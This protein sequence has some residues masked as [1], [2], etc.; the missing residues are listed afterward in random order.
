MSLKRNYKLNMP[1]LLWGGLSENWLLKELGDVHWEQITNE[2]GTASDALVDSRGE[3][4]YASFVRLFWS[5][6]N[7]NQFSEND[8]L[9]LNSDLSRYGS[10]MFFSQTVCSGE[11]GKFNAHLMSVFSTRES[12]DN[13]QLKRGDLNTNINAKGIKQHRKLPAFAK[14]YLNNKAILFEEK[15]ELKTT[16]VLYRQ[17]YPIDAYDDINGVGLLYFASYPKINDKCE[18]NYIKDRYRLSSDWLEVAGTISRDVHYYGNANPEEKLIYELNEMTRKKGI[19][20]L[21]SSLYR[22]SDRQLIARIFTKKALKDGTSLD[23]VSADKTI[24]Q[25]TRLKKLLHQKE[26]KQES[27]PTHSQTISQDKVALNKIIIDFLF[28]MLGLKDLHATSNLS[29]L[30]IESIVY[31]ELSE[32]LHTKHGIS[33]NPSRFYGAT[34]VD[35]LSDD[36]LG[37]PS[38]ELG[39]PSNKP[40]E[41]D[42]VA[43]VGMSGRFPGSPDIAAFWKNIKENK[44]LISE[45]PPDRWDWRVY[46]G[47]N[48]PSSSKMKSKWGGFIEGISEFD[49]LFFGVSPHEARLMDPQQR[50]TMQ[51][52]YAALEDA[53]ISPTSLQGSDT[54]VFIGVSGSD[55]GHLLREVAKDRIE[56]YHSIGTSAS[57]LANRISYFLDIHGPSQAIDTACSSSLVALHEAVKH[58]EDGVCEIA[59]AG[60]VNA[61]FSPELSVSYSQAGMLSEDGKCKTFDERANGYVRSEGVGIVVLKPLSKAQTDGDRI[62]GIIMGSAVNHGGKANTLTAPNPKAQKNLLVKA[63]TSGNID[64]RKVSYIEAHGTGTPLGDPIEL[65]GIKLAFEELYQQ[66][67]LAKAEFAYCGIGSVKTNIGHLEAAAGVAGLIKVLLSLEH[68]TLPGNPHLKTKNKFIDLA[69]SPFYLRKNTSHWDTVE[70]QPRIAGV[71]SF[72]FGGANAH[73]VIKEYVE[74][75]S[76]FISNGA[77]IILLSATNGERLKEL[78]FN[79]KDYL[80]TTEEINLYDVAYT[81][82]VGRAAMTE[83]LAFVVNSVDELINQLTNYQERKTEGFFTGT[84]DTDKLNEKDIDSDIRK[85]IQNKELEKLTESWVKGARIDWRLLYT[86]INCPNKISLPTYPFAREEYWIKTANSDEVMLSNRKVI[87]DVTGFIWQQFAKFS[88]I[89]PKELNE[90]TFISDLGVDSIQINQLT[91]SINSAFGLEVKQVEMQSFLTIA[92]LTGFVKEELDRKSKTKTPID[93]KEPQ[94]AIRFSPAK[95]VQ[96]F[97]IVGLDVEI[98]AAKNLE[99]LQTL[100]DEEAYSLS[101]FPQSRWDALPGHYTQGLS[102]KDFKAKFLENALHFDHKLFKISVREAMMMDPQQRLLLQ[103]V[104]RAIE[105]TGYTRS[106]FSKKQTAV[107]IAINGVDYA[108]I[109]KYDA[110]VDEFSGRGVKRYIA[111]NR[112]SNFFH[113]KGLSETI[114]TACSSFFV[115][116]KKAIDS[117]NSGD[118]EQAIV[119]GVQV[120]LLPFTFQEQLAQGILTTEGRTLPFDA[121]AAG[122]VRSEGVSTIIIKSKMAA[123]RDKDHVYA[124]IKGAGIAHGG[125]AINLTSP[126]MASHKQAFINALENSNVGIDQIQAIEAHGTG[127]PLGDE[128][129]L[130]A[131][132]EVF[133]EKGRTRITP[134]IIGAAKSII[135][136]LEAASGGLA[137]IKSILG[138]QQHKIHGIRGVK[139]INTNYDKEIFSISAA[140]QILKPSENSTNVIG[141]N[142]YGIGGVSAFL[143]F[144]G[145]GEAPALEVE[146]KLKKVFVLSAISTY[147]LRVYAEQIQQFLSKNEKEPGFHFEH[148]LASYQIHRE[149]MKVRLAIVVDGAVDLIDKLDAFVNN[150]TPEKGF[151]GSPD[152]NLNLAI[153][154]TTSLDQV[155]QNWVKGETVNWEI[156]SLSRMPYP[157]YPMDKRK[158]FWVS[159]KQEALPASPTNS[160]RIDK[161]VQVEKS[162]YLMLDM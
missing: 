33:N 161:E 135:G 18:R 71:S 113:L 72:G 17:V 2:L 132:K 8:Q 48:A 84:V 27:S 102:P 122:Y 24:K 58:L 44:D 26:F 125:R 13:K 137:I 106:E 118:C 130:Q 73:V 119:A 85:A 66:H 59:I 156:F 5:G 46:Y 103:S 152:L 157:N 10:K 107:F 11:S 111:A 82:Q 136:H 146:A 50:I 34:S 74:Q 1:Q 109:V 6:D 93:Q 160:Q 65:E 15:G 124:W 41:S 64:P 90:E 120:N 35:D 42:P 14:E 92:E 159:Q 129:E 117:I 37:I 127:M 49:P 57:I 96:D 54:G 142:A 55:Y 32:F 101:D 162:K 126:N 56:A 43:I 83:R 31:L 61:I 80:K 36:L 94:K 110:K 76:S 86:T 121:K 131:F 4:L 69:D 78:V 95:I 114:D 145:V 75:A 40:E 79:L 143:L 70:A 30:G 3:R 147:T 51:A 123:E 138:L 89:D 144:E 60:G 67:G 45:I 158:A 104:W 52:V 77:V 53:A 105:N 153:E 19:V 115:G 28:D 139:E 99:E 116:V 133:L 47:D 100:L 151:Y 38:V 62:Y 22:F 23:R 112:I 81:L 141:L 12:S 39:K 155:A 21:T 25:E 154:G 108:D 91:N 20:Q 88:D 63:Y 87:T 7:I 98:P 148:F 140:D 68:K 97:A 9:E 29:A 150:N 149:V 128:S 16:E 134:C